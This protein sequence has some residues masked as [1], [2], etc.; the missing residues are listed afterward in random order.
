M[1]GRN[2]LHLEYILLANI[3]YTF[4]SVRRKWAYM[5]FLGVSDK[6]FLCQ[7]EVPAYHTFMISLTVGRQLSGLR[8]LSVWSC[9][10]S[11]FKLQTS[12]MQLLVPYNICIIC[13]GSSCSFNKCLISLCF[14]FGLVYISIYYVVDTWIFNVTVIIYWHVTCSLVNFWLIHII[15]A[16]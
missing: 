6:P 16:T 15:Y 1:K 4:V 14:K 7:E 13:Y 2:I 5:P 12:C 10:T 8:W 3:L 9:E 11:E